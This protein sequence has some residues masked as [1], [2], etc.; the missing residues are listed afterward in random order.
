M[1]AGFEP[2]GRLSCLVHGSLDCALLFCTQC[3][4]HLALCIYS[5]VVDADA[6]H[7]ALTLSMTTVFNVIRMVSHKPQV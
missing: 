7:G 4:M 5:V 1:H 2:A 6:L 3:Q